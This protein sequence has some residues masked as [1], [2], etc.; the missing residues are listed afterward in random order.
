MTEPV[1]VKVEARP[2]RRK[3]TQGPCPVCLTGRTFHA[4]CLYAALCWRVLGAYDIEC[5]DRSSVYRLTPTCYLCGA[6]RTTDIEHV[7]PRARGGPNLWS[8]IAGA[9]SACNFTKRAKVD[10]LTTEQ[11]RRAAEH[12]AVYLACFER[13]TDE[14]VTAGLSYHDIL[15]FDDPFVED[16]LEQ[17]ADLTRFFHPRKRR[18]LDLVEDPYSA[19][20]RTKWEWYDEDDR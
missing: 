4:E 20:W 5:I 11:L 3:W 19:E 1:A 15:T 12:Q 8:N 17:G 6:A 18:Y 10:S 9:C 13:C 7:H 2:R 14:V 16:L